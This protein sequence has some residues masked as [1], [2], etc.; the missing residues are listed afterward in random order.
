MNQVPGSQKLM[1][2]SL[3]WMINSKQHPP[4]LLDYFQEHAGFLLEFSLGRS[5]A[6]FFLIFSLD[7]KDSAKGL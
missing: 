1:G 3:L 2:F 7:D 4:D 6:I 5:S